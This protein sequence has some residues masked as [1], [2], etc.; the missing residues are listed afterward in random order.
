MAKEINTRT[1]VT[2]NAPG[3]GYQL[4][5]DRKGQV[6]SL[7]E[8][9]NPVECIAFRDREGVWNLVRAIPI[10]NDQLSDTLEQLFQQKA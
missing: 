3:L 1:L 9:G 5:M 6:Y 4:T 10:I 7:D 8:N 2:F